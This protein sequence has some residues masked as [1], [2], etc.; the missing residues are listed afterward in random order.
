VGNYEK[1]GCCFL[2][3][4]R[5]HETAK[6]AYEDLAELLLLNEGQ[7]MNVIVE[8]TDMSE[9]GYTLETELFPKEVLEQYSLYNLGASATTAELLAR[10]EKKIFSPLR[11]GPQGDYRAGM[12]A[13]LEKVILAL[14]S[15]PTSKRAVLTVPFTDQCSLCVK[16]TDDPEWK[17]LREVYFSIDEQGYLNATSVMR[18]Q[19]LNIFPKNIHYLGTMLQTV[20]AAVG[21]PAGQLTHFM[22]FLVQDRK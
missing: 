6:Q 22:H 14:K 8:L 18:S 12:M 15:K 13:K 4:F 2:K 3:F 5:R 21:V 10:Q 16:T 9:T 11:G 17:C 20:A 19:A 7:A 1:T